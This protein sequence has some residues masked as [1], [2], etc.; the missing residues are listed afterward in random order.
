MESVKL[1]FSKELFWPGLKKNSFYE[2]ATP[3]GTFRGEG[4]VVLPTKTKMEKVKY[5]K[6]DS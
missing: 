3:T 6:Y 2:D 1:T 5:P 4:R